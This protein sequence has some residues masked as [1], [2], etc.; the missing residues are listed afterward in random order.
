MEQ[1]FLVRIMVVVMYFFILGIFVTMLIRDL[2][3]GSV[4]NWTRGAETAKQK[5][6]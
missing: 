6:R 3:I 2:A 1:I 5:E 4:K